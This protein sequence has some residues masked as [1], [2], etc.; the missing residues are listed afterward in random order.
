MNIQGDVKDPAECRF[1]GSTLKHTLVDLGMSP[2]CESYL[3]A[4]QL[5]RMEPFY[6]L[7]VYICEGEQNHFHPDYRK[8]G[9]QWHQPNLD[10]QKKAFLSAKRFAEKEG[11]KIFNATRGGKL[12]IFPRIDLDTALRG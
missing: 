4:E 10:Y 9:E 12:E 2:L 1:C 11:V 3:T 8:P 6:P 5:N 7:K